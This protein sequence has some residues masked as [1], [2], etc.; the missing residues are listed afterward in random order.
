MRNHANQGSEM[1]YAVGPFR[2]WTWHHHKIYHQDHPHQKSSA[3]KDGRNPTQRLELDG[4][5][6]LIEYCYDLVSELAFSDSWEV[7]APGC[8]SK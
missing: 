7:G 1:Y 8:G 4:F 3:R 6:L 5:R 2:Y